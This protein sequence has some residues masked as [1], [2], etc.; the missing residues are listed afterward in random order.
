M[1]F[2]LA[3]PKF[4]DYKIWTTLQN[5]SEWN[6]ISKLINI[7]YWKVGARATTLKCTW[8]ENSVPLKK[9]EIMNIGASCIVAIGKEVEWLHRSLVGTFDYRGKKKG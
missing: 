5:S 3:L 6:T 9:P 8:K 1:L 4:K 7:P 2:T